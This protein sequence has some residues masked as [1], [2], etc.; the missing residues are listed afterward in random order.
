M[1]REGGIPAEKVARPKDFR[2]ALCGQLRKSF[3]TLLPGDLISTGTP[4]GVGLGMK[5][6]QYLKAGDVV[7]LG[8]DGL[9]QSRQQV[10]AWEPAIG[11][12][13]FASCRPPIARGGRA[14]K[15]GLHNQ[16]N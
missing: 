14:L 1:F 16:I 4:H 12:I 3:V 2:H 13:C 7:E 10:F 11:N 5:P 8:I 9:G 15:P 6:P